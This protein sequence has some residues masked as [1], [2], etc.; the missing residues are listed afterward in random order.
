M[1]VIFHLLKK[2][3]VSHG[4]SE[5]ITTLAHWNC[6]LA[7]ILDEISPLMISSAEL[8]SVYYLSHKEWQ[9]KIM[10]NS[11][12]ISGFL[13]FIVNFE[14]YLHIKESL[15]RFVWE[16]ILIQH[17]GSCLCLISEN[18]Q[19]I[20]YLKVNYLVSNFALEIFHINKV[21]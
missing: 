16:N 15:T 17:L 8:W 19:L 21:Y 6:D 20:K 9:W 11:M 18:I 3:F 7:E 14:F 2:N 12:D 1:T 13:C 4:S 10:L 5:V